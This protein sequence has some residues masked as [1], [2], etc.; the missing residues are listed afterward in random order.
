[1]RVPGSIVLFAI[2]IIAI[3]MFGASLAVERL[4]GVDQT[5]TGSIQRVR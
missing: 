2:P 1:M 4:D 3:L 5:M